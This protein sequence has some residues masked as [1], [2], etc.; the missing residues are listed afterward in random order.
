MRPAQ[1]QKGSRLA[2]DIKLVPSDQ[3][4][5]IHSVEKH[6]VKANSIRPDTC[7]MARRLRTKAIVAAVLAIVG[8]CLIPVF[9]QHASAATGSDDFN[10]ANGSLGVNWTDSSDGGLSITSNVV[11]GA[12]T[13]LTVA[14]T[15]TAETYTSDQ[16]SQVEI[17]ATQLSGG[18][19]IGPAVRMQ[20]NGQNLYVGFYYWNN[21]TP[22][23][24]MF[25][26]NGGSWQLLGSYNCG[27]LSAGT[28]LK[29]EAV[30]NT[31]A[32]YEN[33]VLRITSTD[34]NYTGGSPGIVSY[35]AGTV[36]NWSGGTAGFS[37]DYMSTDSNGVASYD[38][39]SANNGWGAQTLRVLQPTSPAPGVPH[40]FLYLLPV[41]A[42]LGNSFGD[43]MDTLRTLDAQNQYNLTIVEPSF[44]AESWYADNPLY[45]Q[46]HHETFMADELAPW[47]DQNLSTSGNEHNWLM[48]FSK[49]GIGGQDLFLKHQD[50]FD[51]VASWDFPAD[52]ATYDQ[53]GG[54][55][56]NS[57]GT[58]ANFQAN[59]RLTS[60]FLDA[61]DANLLTQNRIWIGGW[62]A[63]QTD[64][65][66]YDAL[67]T[68]KG[69]LHSTE[70]PTYMPHRWDSGWVQIALAALYQDSQTLWP[71]VTTTT[72][73]TTTTTTPT[74]STTIATTTTT[75]PPAVTTTTAKQR[76]STATTT[77]TTAVDNATNYETSAEAGDTAST[78]DTTTTIAS[79][80]HIT[81]PGHI[82]ST[83]TSTLHATTTTQTGTNN[84]EGLGSMALASVE[85]GVPGVLVVGAVFVIGFSL[86]GRRRSP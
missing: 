70:T 3:V 19:W 8:L 34:S 17:T 5:V 27:P 72:S 52:D 63:F 9:P 82:S 47:V 35:G 25:A 49:S 61:H 66:D 62:Q 44:N 26:R 67:L 33:G 36:D 7:F 31:L 78:D 16:Y 30:G 71:P 21:G 86:R 6:L 45:P 77:T 20:N 51:L 48:G 79:V 14:D 38:V 28:V 55:S 4:F 13:G 18:D 23:L 12:G 46:M 84:T 43:G 54:S 81:I 10:R 42:G 83:T 60:A 73:T 65:S 32:M 74:T 24:Q 76:S 68:S 58:D 22:E 11:A 80:T 50:V 41:E 59:Y 56:S 69:I 15:R 29:M 85:Y 37:V 75:S 2:H 64:V 1:R 53:F 40:N 57:Y 39:I